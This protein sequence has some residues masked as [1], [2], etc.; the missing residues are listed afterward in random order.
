MNEPFTKLDTR[1]SDTGAPATAWD[2]TRRAIETTKLFWISSVRADGRPHVSSLVA[3]WLDGAHHF[4]AGA[5]EQK[6]LNLRTN[7]HVILTTGC[8]RWDGGLDVVVEGDTIQVTDDAQLERSAEAWTR[9]G[10][11][12]G[13]SSRAT[14]CFTTQAVMPT[15]H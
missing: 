15:P 13:N 6:T 1:F 14:A 4:C 12:A 8:N 2:E 9:N 11:D 5:A 7:P 3:V 10:M